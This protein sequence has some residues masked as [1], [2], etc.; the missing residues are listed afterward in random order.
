MSHA[1]TSRYVDARRSQ[2]G[3]DS[4]KVLTDGPRRCW[5]VTAPLLVRR[6]RAKLSQEIRRGA[7][8]GFLSIGE[9][10][11]RGYK[12]GVFESDRNSFLKRAAE[13]TE[14]LPFAE[15]ERRRRGQRKSCEVRH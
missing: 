3:G 14:R 5:K 6:A 8:P 2:G 7:H 4:P 13:D 11:Y 1:S 12:R 9:R 10:L 15:S